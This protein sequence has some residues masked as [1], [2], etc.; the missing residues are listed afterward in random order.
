MKKSPTE[1]DSLKEET[2]IDVIQNLDIDLMK[3][4]LKSNKRLS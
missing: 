1:T 3:P 2:D 4:N